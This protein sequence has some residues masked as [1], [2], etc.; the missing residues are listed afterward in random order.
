[1]KKLTPFLLFCFFLCPS[2]GG[3]ERGACTVSDGGSGTGQPF[4]WKNYL[5]QTEEECRQLGEERGSGKASF[6]PPTGDDD[7]CYQ[8]YP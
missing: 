1:M 7:D 3:G 2:C 4:F 6:C 5:F 8:V